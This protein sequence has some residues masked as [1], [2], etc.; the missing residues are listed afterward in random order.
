MQTP[1]PLRPRL[2]PLWILVLALVPRLL[3]DTESNLQQEYK[4][5][6]G[7]KL[8]IEADRGAIDITTGPE[9]TLEIKVLRKVTRSSEKTAREIL[10]AHKVTFEQQGDQVMVKGRLPRDEHSWGSWGRGLSVRYVVS[11]PS[12]FNLDFRTAGGGITVASLTGEVRVATAG[13]GIQLAAIEGPVTCRTSGGSIHIE[14]ASGETDARTSG[15]SV[16]VGEAKAKAVLSTSGG[17]IRVK[18]VR[19][20]LQASTS[21]GSIEIGVARALVDASTSGGSITAGFS[22]SPEEDCRLST[23]GGS[24]RVNLP[25]GASA[26]VDARTSGGRVTSHLPV[27]VQGEQR[28]SELV[29]KLGQ[30]GKLLKL[31]TSGGNITLSPL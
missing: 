17:S 9:D 21:G 13:G 23:S 22:G 19:G 24:V 29:G 12:R 16:N 8:V 6:P 28:R 3:A 4:V 26:D 11:V 15:G 5:A 20:P 30:G 2:L 25:E 10:E 1:R 18:E 27:T 14:S 7:G 31:R